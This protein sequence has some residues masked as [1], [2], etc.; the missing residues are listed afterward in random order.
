[1]LKDLQT[2]GRTSRSVQ[3]GAGRGT[4]RLRNAVAR[5][6]LTAINLHDT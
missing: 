1:M 2:A 5:P 4:I 6:P 3:A